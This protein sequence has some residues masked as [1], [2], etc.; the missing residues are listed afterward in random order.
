MMT[1]SEPAYKSLFDHVRQSELL[2]RQSSFADS[3]VASLAQFISG[4]VARVCQGVGEFFACLEVRMLAESDSPECGAEA[5]SFLRDALDLTGSLQKLYSLISPP[6]L[7]RLPDSLL[8]GLERAFRLFVASYL[9]CQRS[10]KIYG[11]QMQQVSAILGS[12]FKATYTA[13]TACIQCLDS[14]D[15]QQMRDYFSADDLSAVT[16]ALTALASSVFELEPRITVTAWKSLIRTLSESHICL[17]HDSVNIDDIV[18]KL[19]S[20]TRQMMGQIIQTGGS[21]QD[22]KIFGFFVKCLVTLLTEY[23]S[24]LSACLSQLFYTLA[25]LRVLFRR[26]ADRSTSDE[27][28]NPE[29]LSAKLRSSPLVAV[30][31]LLGSAAFAQ[32]VIAAGLP[33]LQRLAFQA[34]QADDWPADALSLALIELK[35]YVLALLPKRPELD[36]SRLWLDKS[37]LLVESNLYDSL[38]R[39]LEQAPKLSLLD[40]ALDIG[41]AHSGLD[42]YH[43]IVLAVITSA[44]HLPNSLVSYLEK[45]VIK[46]LFN[47]DSSAVLYLIAS[48]VLCFLLR[49]SSASFCAQWVGLLANSLASLDYRR[50][51]TEQR[52]QLAGRLFA[53]IV[54]FASDVDVLSIVEQY[55]FAERHYCLYLWL[56]FNNLSPS[57][58]QQPQIQSILASIVD[59]LVGAGLE[60]YSA[61]AVIGSAECVRLSALL[62]IVPNLPAGGGL[63]PDRL[64][65]SL[66]RSLT[67]AARCLPS[68]AP[69]SSDARNSQLQ[70]A[71]DLVDALC[72]ALASGIGLA[73]ATHARP[74]A[75]A[76]AVGIE[77]LLHR[78]S[79][80]APQPAAASGCS[81]LGSQI[82]F[83]LANCLLAV[84]G[85][86]RQSQQQQ[87][88]QQQGFFYHNQQQQQQQQYLQLLQLIEIN[89]W[90]AL[91]SHAE[92]SDW[93]G[94]LVALLASV[95]DPAVADLAA[96]LVNQPQQQ[97]QQQLM[98]DHALTNCYLRFAPSHTRL[99]VRA[100]AIVPASGTCSSVASVSGIAPAPAAKKPRLVGGTAAVSS[101]LDD[102]DSLTDQLESLRADGQL[103]G[104]LE[105]QRLAGLV[106]RL[107]QLAN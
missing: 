51:A 56:N 83:A 27:A 26:L 64:A 71:G 34:G 76:A 65:A 79:C 87:P 9:H 82:G 107:C 78:L 49:Y 7:S 54:K 36:D 40:C 3:D 84:A 18:A 1:V 97:Q 22:A 5:A 55:P 28:V 62:R 29:L 106:D 74:L 102:L 89:A 59:N 90:S 24:Q 58:V 96:Q 14:I 42:Y 25:M 46:I 93:H 17:L 94:R 105:K 101:V 92:P 80:P 57:A 61:G 70:C 63:L 11:S 2:Q 37:D 38:I 20:I 32:A 10:T 67:H 50:C 21:P 69:A 43:C 35:C 72:G 31:R 39:T 66:A 91:L 98:S 73:L 77:Q 23:H 103:T 81:T 41:H 100:C 16:Y 68:I 75:E 44:C 95:G 104:L 60:N 13:L 8:V 6:A 85:Y 53:R 45:V 33:E 48:D 15:S 86:R 52:Y 12:L 88:Q 30:E 99:S 4:R 47:P 19:L